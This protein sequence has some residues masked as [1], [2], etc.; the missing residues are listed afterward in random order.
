LFFTKSTVA[1]LA[2]ARLRAK[3]AVV[4]KEKQR[5]KAKAV[6]M[7]AKGIKKK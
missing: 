4:A 5:Q 7:E 2:F 1:T 6:M 3:A